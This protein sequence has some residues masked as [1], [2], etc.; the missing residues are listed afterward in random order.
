MP[1]RDAGNPPVLGGFGNAGGNA[2]NNQQQ[3]Q[4]QQQPDAQ[5]RN[6]IILD[7]S[8]EELMVNPLVINIIQ[9]AEKQIADAGARNEAIE[10]IANKSLKT[11]EAKITELQRENLALRKANKARYPQEKGK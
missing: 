8:A 9:R 6:A 2:G 11:F 5:Q 7:A 1:P 10:A 4:Q 3:N